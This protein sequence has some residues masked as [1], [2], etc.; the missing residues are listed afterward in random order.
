MRIWALFALALAACAST[1]EPSIYRETDRSAPQSLTQ[2]PNFLGY[3]EAIGTQPVRWTAESLVRDFD[4]LMFQTEWGDP[5]PVLLKWEK[6]VT[7]SLA[8]D[9]LAQYRPFLEDLLARIRANAPGLSVSA[10]FGGKGDI[11]LRSAPR[12]EMDEIA[13]NALC[14]FIPFD[15]DWAE[16]K[17]RDA[18][19]DVGWDAIERYEAITVF[20]PAFAPP[21]EIRSCILEEV[22]QALGPGNDLSDLDDSM[23]NDDNAHVWP[24]SFDFLM[25]KALYNETLRN[26][27]KPEPANARAL[28]SLRANAAALG[29]EHRPS[30]KI[31]D[32]YARALTLAENESGYKLRVQAASAA[33]SLAQT[34]G[35]V[36]H[37]LGEAY[38]AAAFVAFE[39]DDPRG[40]VTYLTRAEYAHKRALPPTS[41]HLARVRSEL[42][43]N[44]INL[45]LHDAGLEL[46]EKAIPVF[47]AHGADWQLAHALRWRAIALSQTG[48]W[49]EGAETALEALDWA[50]YVYGGDSRAVAG[51]RTEFIDIG[52]IPANG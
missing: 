43:I 34:P 26:G 20:I 9:E 42:A 41:P 39:N 33:I 3:G 13:A 11:I 14:F 27:L 40:V 6:P 51:W 5:V 37:R 49:T 47:A 10:D 30:D 18:R 4:R 1:P 17:R 19:G 28:K 12:A 7:V 21:H 24:T 23:F 50:R 31:G 2:R 52:L 38:K 32:K 46:I 8:S 29:R 22:T 36:P 15:L 44:L 45:D 25:L 35:A 48:R 16:F